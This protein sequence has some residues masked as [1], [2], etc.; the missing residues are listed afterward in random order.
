MVGIGRAH[1]LAAVTSELASRFCGVD[2]Q[3]VTEAE[4]WCREK[5]LIGARC[6][7]PTLVIDA[8][9]VFRKPWDC[10]SELAAAGADGSFRA[11]LC[12]YQNAADIK[13]HGLSG[14]FLN[15]GL[16]IATPKTAPMFRRAL[17]LYDSGLNTFYADE[18]P[19]NLAIREHGTNV[20]MLSPLLNVQVG[21][22]C[23]TNEDIARHYVG[24]SWQS[25]LLAIKNAE[26]ELFASPCQ[27]ATDPAHT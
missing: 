16:F 3:V 25:K 2:V 23:L 19:I 10:E 27:S 11:A 18:G 12:A 22:Q 5:L 1:A 8:D 13:I 4:N 6:S 26:P 21:S 7:E 24:G 14:A 15:T 9:I 20:V 17:E